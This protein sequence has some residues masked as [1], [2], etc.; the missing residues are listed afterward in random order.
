MVTREDCLLKAEDCERLAGESDTEAT[1]AAFLAEAQKWRALAAKSDVE[2][3]HV[4]TPDQAL[5][6]LG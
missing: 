5:K 1:R 4:D 3:A 6:G 2:R